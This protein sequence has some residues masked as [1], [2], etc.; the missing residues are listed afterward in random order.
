M[1]DVLIRPLAGSSEY[2]A[3]VSIWRDAVD[4]THDFL[5]A[6]DRDQIEGKLESDYFPGVFLTVAERNGELV[7]FSGVL[8]GK[9]EMLFIAPLYRHCGIGTALL[10]DGIEKNGVAEVDVNEQNTAVLGFY[11]SHGFE[12]VRRRETDEAGRP[13]PMLGMRIRG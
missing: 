2:A 8:D 9:L 12:I 5:S 6:A 1:R 7:G 11:A 13:Y 3:L 10:L 4:A